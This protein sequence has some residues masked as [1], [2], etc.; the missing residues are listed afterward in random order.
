MYLFVSVP[1]DKVCVRP[2]AFERVPNKM[3]R[4]L[5]NALKFVSSKEACLTACLEEVSPSIH[6]FNP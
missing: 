4:G 1:T 2:W 6:P 3:I 5:D